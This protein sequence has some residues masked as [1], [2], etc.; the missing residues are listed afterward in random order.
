MTMQR[1]SKAII[2]NENI[3]DALEKLTVELL[4]RMIQEHM[5]Q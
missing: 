4:E 3:K 2:S 1:E 5:R